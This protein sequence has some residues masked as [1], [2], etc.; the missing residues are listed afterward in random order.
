MRNFIIKTIGNA[1]NIASY[2]SSEYASNKALNLFATPRKGRYS[3]AQKQIVSSAKE[4]VLRVNNL[5]ITT[6]HW[7][8]K[9]KTILLAHG[10]ESN[11]SRWDY[12]LNDL[13]AQD[14]NI[15]ALDAPAHGKSDGKQFNAILY[16][17]CIAAIAQKFKPEVIIGHSVGGMAT[18][19]SL[20]NHDLPFV[21]KIVLLGAPAH[22]TGVFSRYKTMMGY[23]K[24][25]ENGLE[26]IIVER[27][28][29]NSDYFS[30]ADFSA[31]IAAEGLIIHDK[32]DKIIPYEDALL[33]AK[34]YQNAELI[35]TTGFGHGLRDTSLTPKMI[36]FINA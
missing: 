33:F 13:K 10:W 31:S 7:L 3:E 6:Y 22:F 11:T 36:T 30:A 4:E 24:R 26:K 23:N 34:R 16:S 2:F 9:N 15:I 5:D 17:E 18:V 12:I 8:G 28:N 1:L 35:T 25:I 27:F 14:Y 20:K 32:K 21:K 29:H 19:F